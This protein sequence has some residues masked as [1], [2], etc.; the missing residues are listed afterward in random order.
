[1][2]LTDAVSAFT[3]WSAPWTFVESV[4]EQLDPGES[5]LFDA[6]VAEASRFEHWN[7]ADLVLGCKIAHRE[8]K[9]MFPEVDHQAIASVVRAAS[10][11]WA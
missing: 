4:R 8:T 7:T 6:V 9:K 1:M 2:N 11:D 10:Y 5:R 3:N